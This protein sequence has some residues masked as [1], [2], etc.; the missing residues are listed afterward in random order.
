MQRLISSAASGDDRGITLLELV[1]AVFV[2]SI[3]IVAALRS[4]DHAQRNLGEEAARLFAAQVALNRAEA[5][6][7]MGPQSALRNLPERVIYGP[8]EWQVTVEVE[9]TDAGLMQSTIAAGAPG[10]PGA[11]FVML[12]VPRTGK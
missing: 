9:E 11:R 6:R 7:L 8:Y 1:I 2:L 10:Q 12:S 3:V 4:V 5:I